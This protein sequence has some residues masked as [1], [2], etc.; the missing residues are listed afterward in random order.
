MTAIQIASDIHLEFYKDR[1]V[2]WLQNFE[3]VAD[4][5]ILAGDI[6]SATGRGYLDIVFESVS[7]RWKW[8]IY[9]AGNHEYYFTS[10]AQGWR[11]IKDAASR[12]KNVCPL[13]NE[14]LRLEG[15]SFLGGTGWFPRTNYPDHKRLM[16]D[17]HYIK[18]FEPD[19]YDSNKDFAG[20]LKFKPYDVVVTHHLPIDDCVALEYMGNPLNDFFVSKLPV[21]AVQTKF[22]IFGHTH[23]SVNFTRNGSRFIAN[24]KGYPKSQNIGWNSKFTIEV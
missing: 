7:K 13:N 18:H 14:L 24:P 12:Y 10:L 1:G 8:V 21:D 22:Y 16:S 9:V 4:I 19:V 3:P 17:F 15:I 6:T 20:L 23:S 11:N 5:L 2:E